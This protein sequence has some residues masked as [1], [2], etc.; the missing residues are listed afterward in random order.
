MLLGPGVKLSKVIISTHTFVHDQ[1]YFLVG[2]CVRKDSCE[3][4]KS[5][6]KLV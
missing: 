1:Y 3:W 5:C 2:F 6:D 4:P